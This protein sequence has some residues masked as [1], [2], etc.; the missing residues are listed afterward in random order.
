MPTLV[1]LIAALLLPSGSLT[2]PATAEST[3][4]KKSGIY[5]MTPQGP[6]EL[7]VSGERNNVALAIGL[8]SYYSPE[9]FDRIPT[10]DSVQTFYVSAMG[11][12]PRGVHLVVGREYLTNA[13]DKYQRFAGRVVPRG[14]VAFEIKSA[15]LESQDFLLRAVRKLAP[16]GVADAELEV[17]L[18]LEL[19]ST[20]GLND[21]D[22]PIRIP[23]PKG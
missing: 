5:A 4:P 23:V 22:Y 14:A 12:T 8:K 2:A 13:L 17:Y 19:R 15:D 1:L 16:A 3:Y 18:V 20:S 9:T 21:R 11:W 7:T 6:V 10:A